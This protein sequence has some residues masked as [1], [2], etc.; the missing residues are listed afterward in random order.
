MPL[1]LWEPALKPR[2]VQVPCPDS[3]ELTYEPVEHILESDVIP[4]SQCGGLID[5]TSVDCVQI[6]AAVR[7]QVTGE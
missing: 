7:A 6:V 1:F 4:C 3:G 2:T 5:L